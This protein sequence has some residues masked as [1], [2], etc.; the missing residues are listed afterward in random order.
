MTLAYGNFSSLCMGASESDTDLFYLY[1]FF[2]FSLLPSFAEL[3]P[4][5]PLRVHFPPSDSMAFLSVS[6][7]GGAG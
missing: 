1:T 3:L 2:S 7:E 6:E 5:F 4:V